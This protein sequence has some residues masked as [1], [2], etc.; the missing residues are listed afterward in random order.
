MVI[1]SAIPGGDF[2]FEANEDLSADQYR[3]VVFD[4]TAKKVR[5]PDTKAERP[6]GILQNDPAA[7]RSAVVRL[8][9]RSKMRVGGAVALNDRLVPEFVSA[10]DAGKGVKAATGY[11][12]V[13]GIVREILGT[14]A[15]DELVGV[16]IGIEPAF[17]AAHTDLP[18]FTAN[19]TARVALLAVTRPIR[20]VRIDVVAYTIPSDADG[21]CTIQVIN[22]DLSATTEDELAAAWNTEGLTAK[23]PTSLTLTATAADLIL[24][25]GDCIYAVLVNNSA[26]I[27]T[28]WA[29]AG[30]T[31]EYEV[32][33]S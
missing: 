25:E 33:P 6:L 30:A 7:G 13:G 16:D 12:W 32:M 17:S 18:T 31:I 28:N 4:T 21:T 27:D 20:V 22:Y 14:A 24:A 5:R 11:T 9:G 3:W 1:E 8:Y 23:T 2:T 29:A 26:A 19:S 10:A 15:E